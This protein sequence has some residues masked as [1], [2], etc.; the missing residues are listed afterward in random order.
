MTADY[1]S[2][3]DFC[4]GT[5]RNSWAA[6]DNITSTKEGLAWV[7]QEMKLCKPLANKADVL[8]FK[9]FL[10]DL[11]T[12]VAMM[13]YPYSTSF[14]MPLPGN[15]VKAVCKAIKENLDKPLDNANKTIIHGI[16]AGVNVYNN[17]TGKARENSILTD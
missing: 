7:N 14:L 9:A 12:N 3:G 11:W 5:I 4:S 15:P 10:N 16:Q 6:I 1:S 13:D 17:F 8:K 2:E